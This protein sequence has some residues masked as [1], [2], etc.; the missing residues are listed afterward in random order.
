[1]NYLKTSFALVSLCLIPILMSHAHEYVSARPDSHA[2]ITVMADHTHKSGDWMLS[3]RHMRMEMDGMRSNET[4]QSSG[5]V[6]KSNYTVTPTRMTMDMTMIGAMYAPNDKVTL[7]AML[8]YSDSKMNHEIFAMAAPLIS[9]NGGLNQFTTRSS[10]WG[11][12]KL[13]AAFPFYHS[14]G[15]KAH[16]GIGV[17]LPAGSIAETDLIPGPGGRLERQLPAPMQLGSGTIDA[18]PSITFLSQKENW[19]Y[20]FQANGRIRLNNNHH[21]YRL[22]HAFDTSGWIASR[23]SDRL[24]ISARLAYQYSGQMKGTQ[25]DIS[26]NP[27]FA[28]SR[29]TVTTAFSENYGGQRAD[30]AIGINY[31]FN[32]GNFSGNRIALELASPIFEDLNGL[33][34]KAK[35]ITTFG[36][37]YSW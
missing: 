24:S 14:S 26:F 21:D 3:V 28:L 36:W 34:L 31:Y 13:A 8:P 32:D 29:R 27:P 7:I 25:S 33:Q 12:L 2:P 23:F 22:G 9:L 11:D 17:S 1:M 30:L 4:D 16:Y 15:T 18:T 37:Q 6:F 5:D 20:G 19:S 35:S 10:G